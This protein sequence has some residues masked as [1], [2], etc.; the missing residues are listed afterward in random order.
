[1][2]IIFLGFV[3][4]NHLKKF[5]ETQKAYIF[6]FRVIVKNLLRGYFH[7]PTSKRTEALQVIGQI[8]SFTKEEM[9]E[10]RFHN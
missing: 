10:V 5:I 9:K 2:N 4:F 3:E 8:L 1:M 6:T 7:A